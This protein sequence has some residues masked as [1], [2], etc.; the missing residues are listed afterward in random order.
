MSLSEEQLADLQADIG[1]AD[2]EQVFT[3]QELQRLFARAGEVYNKA[4]V[5]A[6]RQL[7]T[8]AAKFTDYTQ[9]ASSEKRSQM[10]E[11]LSKLLKDAEAATGMS[12][13]KLSSGV[14]RLGLDGT[15][16]NRETWDGSN[17]A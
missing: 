1:I 10:F 6:L 14:M 17:D 4:L 11:H 5:F 3:D 13:G 16:E 2:D 15:E 12:G 9:N 7:R 8:N